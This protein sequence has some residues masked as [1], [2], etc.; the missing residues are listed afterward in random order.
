MEETVQRCI[1]DILGSNNLIHLF[2]GICVDDEMGYILNIP[3]G[4]YSNEINW[5]EIAVGLGH[6]FIFFNYMTIKY[7]YTFKRIKD[8]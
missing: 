1:I 7:A 5:Q 2:T 4:K 8:I 3:M 6:I